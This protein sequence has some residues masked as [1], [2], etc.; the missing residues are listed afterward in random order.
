M[1]ADADGILVV[2]LNK[3]E[4]ADEILKKGVIKKIRINVPKSRLIFG[5]NSIFL[6]LGQGSGIIKIYRIAIFPKKIVKIIKKI[7]EKELK[8]YFSFPAEFNYSLWPQDDKFL[9][10]FNSRLRKIKLTLTDQEGGEKEIIFRDKKDILLDLKPWKDK[11]VKLKVSLNDNR[12]I[13]NI[14]K[15]GFIRYSTEENSAALDIRDE[16]ITNK[17]KYSVLVI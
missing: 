15:S 11:I 16:L 2:D 1:K 9:L 4:I 12:L 17:E 10:S 5:K 3:S 14:K 6:K 8:S 13:A 7:P